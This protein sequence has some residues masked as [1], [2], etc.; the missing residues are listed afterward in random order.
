[1]IV[2]GWDLV[3]CGSID[4]TV[5]SRLFCGLWVVYCVRRVV[6]LCIILVLRWL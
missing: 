4:V 2:L 5:W 1:M 6:L 3:V